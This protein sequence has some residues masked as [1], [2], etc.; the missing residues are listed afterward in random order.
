MSDALDNIENIYDNP[1]E[2]KKKMAW[3]R[4][5]KKNITT[6]HKKDVPKGLWYKSPSGK[7]I[8]TEELRANMYVSPDDDFHV[9]IGSQEYFEILFDNSQY[10]EL[11]AKVESK[12]P[13]NWSDTQKYKDRLKDVKKKTGLT[14]AIR[15]A[16]G[17]MND[18]EVVISA[19]DFK[20][21]GGSLGSAMGEKI[22][23][24]IDYALKHN[25]P[26]ILITQ[27]GGARMMEA[28]ISLMQLAKVEAK[29]TQLSDAKIPYITLLTNPT[30]GGI[31]ASFGSVGDLVLAEPGALIGF[32]GPRVIKETIGR[33]LP[34]GFQ[35]SEFLLEKGFID[36]IVHRKM[37]KK[38][39]TESINLLMPTEVEKGRS[40]K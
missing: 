26:Y 9:Q 1:N 20:F 31:T 14:D 37:L 35:T 13:L 4:R 15:N 8:D 32:A 27:S 16:T 25:L 23:R 5:T 3:F 34:E 7:I 12:D 18:R 11:D 28:A 40:K 6:E 10:K 19:M 36:M 30:Y 2:E 21:I 17:K 24:A 39:L 38:Q 29:L 33:D 22:V